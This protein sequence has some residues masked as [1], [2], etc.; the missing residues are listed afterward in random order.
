MNFDARFVVEDDLYHRF[1]EILGLIALASVVVHIRPLE[2]L[3]NPSDH[4]AMFV[5]SLS[6]AVAWFL[7]ALR[8]VELAVWAHGERKLLRTMAIKEVKMLLMGIAIFTTAAVIAGKDYFAGK[9]DKD[10][11]Y[12]D[13]PADVTPTNATSNRW[14]A[15][16][17]DPSARN[18]LPIWLVLTVPVAYW[19]IYTVKIIFFFPND[20]SHKKYASHI[21]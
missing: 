18:D 6:L 10:D 15:E 11:A 17:E 1:F 7:Q 20:G 2:I 9:D 16:K 14:L 19:A 13:A 8:F 12:G 5:L 3:S 4:D 21:I